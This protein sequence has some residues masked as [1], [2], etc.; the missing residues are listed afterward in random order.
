MFKNV[1]WKK[2]CLRCCDNVSFFLKQATMTAQNKLPG[3]KFFG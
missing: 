1:T 3:T 2:Y